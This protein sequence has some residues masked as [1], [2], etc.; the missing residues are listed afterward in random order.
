MEQSESFDSYHGFSKCLHWV[1]A[2]I[3]LGLLLVGFYMTLLE[4]SDFKLQLYA[5]HK[6]FGLLVLGLFVIRVL[7]HCIK[8]KP[9]ALNTHSKVEKFAAHLVHLILYITLFTMP[10][11][12]WVMSSAGDFTVQFFGFDVPDIVKK[13][14]AVFEQARFIHEV[15]SFIL[16]G[17]L[18]LHILGGLKHHFID[19]DSTLKRMT[20]PSLGV[21]GGIGLVLLIGALYAPSVLY[22]FQRFEKQYLNPPIVNDVIQSV[23]IHDDTHNHDH[24]EH[25]HEQII[26][27]EVSEWEIDKELSR[28]TFAATQY[29]QS[30]EGIFKLAETQIFFDEDNLSNSKVRVEVD[31]G[32]IKTG[33]DDRDKQALSKDWFDAQAYPV[34]VFESDSFE[35]TAANH[36]ISKGNLT[37]RGVRLEISL[38]FTL[39]IVQKS[40]A[41]R[42]ATMAAK[43]DLSRLD[44]G[45]GQGQ[46]QAT[47]AIGEIVTLDMTVIASQK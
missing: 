14:K 33:S 45:V 7:W 24:H 16:V 9:K 4:F 47:E 44:F 34:A 17:A 1:T 25:D 21:L 15:L 20:Y 8:A 12:G 6:S 26:V 31:I 38:P 3:I 18:G 42:V 19:S 39:N 27:S 13:D 10:I 43:L 36:F 22:A 28:I 2:L 41:A 37:L 23:H 32:S 40:E 35:K 11:S 29:G 30:F 5:N 46:W